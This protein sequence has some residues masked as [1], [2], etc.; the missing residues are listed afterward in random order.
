MFILKNSHLVTLLIIVVGVESTSQRNSENA[1][2]ALERL[3]KSGTSSNSLIIVSLDYAD[4]SND[5]VYKDIK[6]DASMRSG[7][8]TTRRSS[9]SVI[10][11][12]YIFLAYTRGY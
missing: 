3:T 9:L 2:I 1:S 12:E 6:S 11:R 10:F 8:L 4:S 7:A 5:I